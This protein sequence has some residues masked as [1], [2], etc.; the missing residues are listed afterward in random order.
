MMTNAEQ[1]V[2]A[3]ALARA[4]GNVFEREE[5]AMRARAR[6]YSSLGPLVAIFDTF[7]RPSEEG[8]RLADL[9]LEELRSFR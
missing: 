7:R 8:N 3:E 2:S 9:I 5:R 6:G 1:N 4:I